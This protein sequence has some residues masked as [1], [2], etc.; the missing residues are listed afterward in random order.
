MRNDTDR[1]RILM[2]IAAHLASE[3]SYLQ[4]L[5]GVK[6]YINREHSL[7]RVRV[8]E[9]FFD[10]GE[11]KKGELVGCSTSIGRQQN[12]WLISF[13]E[14]KHKNDPG[15]LLLRA[16]G[17][18]DTCD[19]GNE[20]FMRITGIPERFL[21]EGDKHQFSLKLQKAL[22]N[23]DSWGHRFRGLE[24]PEPGVAHVFIGEVFGGIGR[25]TKPYRIDIKFDKKTTIKSITKQ[26]K[27][28][29]F[30]TREFELMDDKYDGPMQG[31]AKITRDDLVGALNA[32]GIQLK[33]QP[34]NP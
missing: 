26:M 12:K 32:S 29:G 16:V 8:S 7:S 9:R 30:G 15:G 1:E 21:W 13:V 28:Q 4:S 25:D 34:K 11:Y 23:F 14:G 5:P 27:D 31:L 2:N 6:E 33:D 3:V 22:R 10:R 17:T 18:N 19:Y 24:F 20:S